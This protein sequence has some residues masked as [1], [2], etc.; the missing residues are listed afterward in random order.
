MPTHSGKSMTFAVGTIVFHA[1]KVTWTPGAKQIDVTNEDS[2]GIE[3]YID[4]VGTLKGSMRG[5][6]DLTTAMV[7]PTT[8]VLATFFDGA[9]TWTATIKVGDFTIDAGSDGSIE[10]S[11]D[12][13]GSAS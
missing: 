9:H 8:G 3:E 10:V 12:F 13:V 7:R 5:V 1:S 6:P 11:F 4:G 2:G